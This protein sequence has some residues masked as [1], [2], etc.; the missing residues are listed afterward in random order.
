MHASS[1]RVGSRWDK[2]SGCSTE[3]ARTLPAL[4]AK[5]LRAAFVVFLPHSLF[6]REK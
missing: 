2:L 4:N 3:A 6:Q 5:D 1:E